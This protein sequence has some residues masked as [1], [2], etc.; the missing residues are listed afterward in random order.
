[1]QEQDERPNARRVV[2]GLIIVLVGLAMLADRNGF[3]DLQLSSRYW[4]FI[5]I[6]LGGARL[7][8]PPRRHGRRSGGG[9]LWVGIW[10]LVT[11]FHVFGFDYATSWPLLIIG[12][13]VGIAWNAFGGRERDR[14]IQER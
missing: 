1:M 10:G 7:F 6:L 2:V 9:L 3:G 13:G 4:P 12:V 11:E 14:P 5:L 8:D